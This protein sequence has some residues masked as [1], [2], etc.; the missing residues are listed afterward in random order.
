[1]F[2]LA[3]DS[4]SGSELSYELGAETVSIGASG[5]NDVV[6]TAPGVAPTHLV[7]RRSGETYTF[8]SQPRQI[9]LLNGTRRARGVLSEGDKIRLG[10]TTITVCAMPDADGAEAEPEAE[11]ELAVARGPEADV[12]PET[13]RAEVALFN[14]PARLA[15]GRRDA[16]ELFQSAV[17]TDMVAALEDYLK[18][19]FRGARA[20]L[21]WL[22][23][24]GTLQ[25]IVSTWG[26]DVPQL[27]SRT[28]SEL[29]VGGRVAMLRGFHPEVLI[30]P[31]PLG[32]GANVYLLAETNA[33]AVDED[34]ILLAELAAL[35]ALNWENVSGS[36]A[37]FGR[38][39]QDAAR[40]LEARLPGTSQAVADLREQLL[41]AARSA[42]PVM[43][44]GRPGSGRA[45]LASLIASLC[46]TGKPWIRI[47]QARE[48]EE[49][50]IRV[51]LFG[52]DGSVGVRGLAERAGGG[53][54]VVRDVERLSAALQRDLAVAVRSDARSGFGPK[55]RWILTT[56][57]AGLGLVAEGRLDEGLVEAAQ[58]HVIGV[59]RLEQRREDMPIVIVRALEAVSS[60]QGKKVQG[61]ALETLDSLLSHPFEGQMTELLS[62]LRRLV[63]A[64]PDGEMVQGKVGPRSSEVAVAAVDGDAA[65]A[66]SVLGQDDLKVV[67]PAVERILID[68]VL[69]R[70][71]GNQSKAA[72]ELNLSR[73]ALIAKIK[74][75][76]IP[77][78]R[79][80]RRNR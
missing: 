1:V 8:V 23:Q 75:Y 66:A 14:E 79:S 40:R 68:R 6:V 46:P 78:Y 67:I 53:V 70:S 21:A 17:Q 65:D 58:K 77:D 62:E 25:P 32:E 29:A 30:Y 28:F 60:E 18:G 12:R 22:D 50:A 56:G 44:H 20:M 42:S 31:V 15:R 49:S 71:L 47:V 16:V 64:T 73:G 19:V 4:G 48:N 51:E 43:L 61:I 11:A 57:D 33:E 63:T 7:I 9:V 24:K 52:S 3:I 76:G 35:L 27:P 5:A 69:R 72:R 45:Y 74:E 2:K 37:F 38:W 39:E 10:T 34:R 13:I 54:V 41:A 80:L 59:P 36:S 26:G 55:V